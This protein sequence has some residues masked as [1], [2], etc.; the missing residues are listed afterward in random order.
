MKRQDG[1]Q[2][3][4]VTDATGNHLGSKFCKMFS[5]QHAESVAETFEDHEW[6]QI[7]RSYLVITGT[8][9]ITVDC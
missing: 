7:G 3:V 4:K 1:W 5:K 8:H 6:R 2:T 9:A